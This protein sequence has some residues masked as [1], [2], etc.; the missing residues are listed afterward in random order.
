MGCPATGV[1]VGAKSPH[2]LSPGGIF[3]FPPLG[4]TGVGAGTVLPSLRVGKVSEFAD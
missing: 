2:E 1:L 3:S 4:A